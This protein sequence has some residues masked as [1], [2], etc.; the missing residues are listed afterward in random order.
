[1]KKGKLKR[2]L[3][4]LR[5]DLQE[6][7]Q[8]D[9]LAK[10][11]IL[12]FFLIIASFLL[13]FLMHNLLLQNRPSTVSKQAVPINSPTPDKLAIIQK[14]VMKDSYSIPL[15]W[16][17]LG[18][19]L[20]RDGVIDKQKLA[21]AVV[22]ADTLPEDLDTYFTGGQDSIE[23]TQQNAQFWVDVF[24]GLGLANRN[25]LLTSGPM[26]EGSRTANFAST[27]GYTIGARQPMEIYAKSSYIPL[28]EVQQ[29]EVE[30]IAGS[31]YRPCCGNSTAFPDCNHGMAALGLVELMVSQNFTKEEIYKTVLAFNTY[32]FPGT[33]LDV[34]YYFQQN[35]RDYS[36]VPA[37]ELLSKTFSSAMGY[38]VIHKKV[39]N[40]PWPA[41][42]SGGSC[43]A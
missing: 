30:E 38:Q 20:L 7:A 17:D 11:D 9:R 16:G 12:M 28:S 15:R 29:K 42:Q 27:G 32:W 34:A 3:W 36:K 18:E 33:Y 35:G 37:K 39:G 24:W 1:M 10:R 5:N 4:R 43:G 21:K 26:V 40:L 14:K 41:L 31:I 8:L 22:G 2:D 6:V 13:G 25:S 23:V 19:R